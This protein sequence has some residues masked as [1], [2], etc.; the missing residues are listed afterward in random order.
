MRWFA[1]RGSSDSCRLATRAPVPGS[2][3][4]SQRTASA[5]NGV[6]AKHHALHGVLHCKPTRQAGGRFEAASPALSGWLAAGLSRDCSR[7]EQQLYEKRR[8]MTVALCR[9]RVVSS[10]LFDSTD[11]GEIQSRI[12]PALTQQHAGACLAQEHRIFT[13][14]IP[15]CLVD[16]GGAGKAC[17]HRQLPGTRTLPTCR[18]RP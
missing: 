4:H 1:S 14:I 6:D 18:L 3:S 10:G 17:T 11:R 15:G 2:R 7:R 9:S 13:H 12:S 16:D 8:H 5:R